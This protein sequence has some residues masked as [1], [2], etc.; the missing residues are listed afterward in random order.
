MAGVHRFDD[1]A[2]ALGA[3]ER[4]SETE[5]DLADV[6][7][8]NVKPWLAVAQPEQVILQEMVDELSSFTQH[9]I[10]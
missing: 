5:D 10:R 6:Q 7:K 8:E 1:I 4:L 9:M 2:L 3:V